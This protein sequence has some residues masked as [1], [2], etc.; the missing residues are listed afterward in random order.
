MARLVVEFTTQ[1]GTL[2]RYNVVLVTLYGG[3]WQTVRVYDNRHGAHDMHRH[4][5]SGGKQPAE[6][7]HHGTAEEAFN[8]AVARIKAGYEE[9]VAGWL[10]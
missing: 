6:P 2:T 9:M 4:T 7:F 3:R 5:L 1:R 10:G 8:D